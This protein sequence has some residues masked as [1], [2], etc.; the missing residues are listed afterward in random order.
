MKV[1]KLIDLLGVKN[2]NGRDKSDERERACVCVYT[3]GM[4][5]VVVMRERERERCPGSEGKEKKSKV[6]NG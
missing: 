4:W 1:E 2:S 3:R 5:E 6:K